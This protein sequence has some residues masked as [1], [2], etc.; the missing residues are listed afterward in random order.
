MIKTDIYKLVRAE[1]GGLANIP[2][3]TGGL[4]NFG[5]TSMRYDEYRDNRGLERRSVREITEN[6]VFDIYNEYWIESHAFELRWPLDLVHFA[7]S[8]N[9]GITRGIKL[10]Q[11]ALNLIPDGIVGHDT[12][13]AIN[14]ACSN[15]GLCHTAAYRLLLEQVF[16]YDSLDEGHP[17][18][19]KFVTGFWLKRLKHIYDEIDGRDQNG[20]Y[21][22]NSITR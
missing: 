11:R 8:F 5:I 14:L 18:K 9:A 22:L 21:R 1:E 12:K 6:E 4:T 17:E 20:V 10:L 15:P 2:G 3:D 13:G 7:F 16:F 19:T